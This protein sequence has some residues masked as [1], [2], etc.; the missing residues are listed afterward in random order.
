MVNV[1][2]ISIVCYLIAISYGANGYHWLHAFL[3]PFKA[4]VDTLA[5]SVFKVGVRHC[6]DDKISKR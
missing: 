2:H 3:A 5:N 6:I 4:G 1:T